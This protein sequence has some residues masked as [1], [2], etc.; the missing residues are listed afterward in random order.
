MGYL[1]VREMIAYGGEA[2]ALYDHLS[3]NLYPPQGGAVEIARKAIDAVYRGEAD[4]IIALGRTA[5]E[6]VGDLHLE[7]FLDA[8]ADADEAAFLS[9][10][11]NDDDEG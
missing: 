2:L 3:A 11:E 9:D 1:R 4:A 8:R 10:V 7:A 5:E 6:V